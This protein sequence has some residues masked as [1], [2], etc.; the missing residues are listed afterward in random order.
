M[1]FSEAA[2]GATYASEVAEGAAFQF[3]R[4]TK[5]RLVEAFVEV[6]LWQVQ[7][8][9]ANAVQRFKAASESARIN[10]P[11]YPRAERDLLKAANGLNIVC[12]ALA[13]QT[14][15]AEIARRMLDGIDSGRN[16][17]RH[18]KFAD[19]LQGIPLQAGSLAKW[20]ED[21]CRLRQ[22][23]DEYHRTYVR[24]GRGAIPNH[25]RR[26]FAI[27]V[28][29]ILAAMGEPITTYR[30]G[31]FTKVLVILLEAVGDDRRTDIS[32]L[33]RDAVNRVREQSID[34]DDL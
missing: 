7:A 18:P 33:V 22:S 15:R 11:N 4:D 17:R 16:T 9:L 3:S 31:S 28:A 6:E 8:A 32:R 12:D 21:A 26:Y 13:G 1:D 34:L 30:S 25:S 27:H 20:L 10:R 19:A 14:N 29:A 2:E 5:R 24:R 23:L